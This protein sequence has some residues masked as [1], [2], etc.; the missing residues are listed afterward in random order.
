MGK[1]GNHLGAGARRLDIDR[2]NQ[3]AWMRA[4]EKFKAQAVVRGQVVD[5]ATGTADQPGIF[6][7]FDRTADPRLSR[8]GHSPNLGFCPNVQ[9]FLS[10]DRR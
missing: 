5:E 4:S 9:R 1:D 6:P 2:G 8:R 10:H 3:A 7:P